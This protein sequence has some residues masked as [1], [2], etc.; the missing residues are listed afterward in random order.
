MSRYLLLAVQM[1]APHGA[2]MSV[3]RMQ[4]MSRVRVPYFQRTVRTPRYDDTTGHLRGPDAPCVTNQGA[5][6][7]AGAG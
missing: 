1:H 7:F 6:A 5:Q 2:R 3:Q 4:T